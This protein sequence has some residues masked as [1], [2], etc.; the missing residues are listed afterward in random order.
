MGIRL[1]TARAFFKNEAELTRWSVGNVG[2]EAIA[3]PPLYS[4]IVDELLAFSLHM[5]GERLRVAEFGAGSLRLVRDLFCEK[6]KEVFGLHLID[7][8]KME[9]FRACPVQ[10]TV[11]ESS[12]AFLKMG[13]AAI[14]E[15]ELQSGRLV[16]NKTDAASAPLNLSEASVDLAVSRNF[17]MHHSPHSLRFHLCE[18]ARVLKPRRKYLAVVLN[19]EYQRRKLKS[20]DPTLTL[21]P[22]KE[23]IFPRGDAKGSLGYYSHVFHSMLDYVDLFTQ[24][25][26]EVADAEPLATPPGWEA[27]LPRYYDP[28][29]PVFLM[30]TAFKI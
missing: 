28:F 8:H 20:L 7:P 10:V 12:A 3:N 16:I 5:N 19:P 18:A 22:G 14:P 2:I 15:S 26:F 25:G 9:R 21:K 24:S 6:P 11:F 29:V 23:F 27:R 1:E 4:R 13:R 30:I 17:L